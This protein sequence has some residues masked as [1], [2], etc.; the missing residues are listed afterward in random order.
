MITKQ[1][2]QEGDTVN[3]EITLRQANYQDREGQYSIFRHSVA[4]KDYYPWSLQGEKCYIHTHI[5]VYVTYISSPHC[6]KT[7]ANHQHPPRN[8]R[9]SDVKVRN[10]GGW[11]GPRNSTESEK[12]ITGDSSVLTS[13]GFSYS[14]HKTGPFS[15]GQS[16]NW[17]SQWRQVTESQAGLGDTA[18]SLPDSQ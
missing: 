11:T 1:K 5:C 4:W 3:L 12:E 8:P 7:L 16:H 14:R 13:G 10:H 17:V 2:L 9:T 6:E 18:G 15:P